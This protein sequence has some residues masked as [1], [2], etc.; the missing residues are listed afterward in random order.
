MALPLPPER[1]FYMYVLRCADGSL[2]T[3]YTVDLPRRLAT[4][5]AGKASKYT[6]SRRPVHLAAWSEFPTQRAAMQ[7]E[8]AFKRL[9]RAQKVRELAT[10]LPTI[11][12][13]V[14]EDSRSG[15]LPPFDLGIVGNG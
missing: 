14:G 13:R 1:G 11:R 8:V 3:G 15:A 12:A 4:H 9:S 10:A 6:R 5:Q 7:A 2:Y